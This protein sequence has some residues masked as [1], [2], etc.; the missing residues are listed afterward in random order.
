VSA[1]APDRAA[2][3]AARRAAQTVFGAPLVITAGAGTGK[4]TVLVARVLAWCLGPGWE[5]AERAC[6]KPDGASP[7]PREVAEHA[8]ERVVAI[9]FTEAAAAEMEARTMLALAQVAAGEEV[10]G[11]D[12]A[13]DDGDAGTRRA[14]AHALLAAFDRLHVQTIHAF[15]RRLLANHPLE[16][17]IH[18]RFRVD[19]RG[20]ERAVA[21][22][23]VLEARLRAMADEGDPDLE[24]ALLHGV[25]A[26][27]VAEMLEALLA[28]AVP[29]DAFAADPLA[30]ERVEAFVAELIAAV[31]ALVRAIGERFEGIRGKALGKTVAEAARLSSARLTQ[32]DRLPELLA[33]LETLWPKNLLDRLHEWNKGDWKRA[34][35]D[36]VGEAALPIGEAARVLRPLLRRALTVDVPLLALVHRTLAPLLAAASQRLREVGAESF[37]AL[38]RK[39]R[40]LLVQRPDVAERVRRDIDQ[41][42]VDEFQDTDA[43]QCEIVASLALGGDAAARPG[44]F[45][46]G[47]PKQSVYGWRNADIGAYMDFVARVGAE[48]GAVA[49]GLCVNHRSVPAV[50]DEVASVIEPAMRFEARVQ[51]PFEALLPSEKNAGVAGSGRA[52]LPAVEYWVSAD[53]DRD[54]NVLAAKTNAQRA[55]RREAA[56]LARDLRAVHEEQQI[57]WR[58]VAL[59]FRSTGDLDEYMSVLRSA[60]IPYTVDRDRSYYRR[61]EVVEA[62]A[63]VR[64]V[65]DPSDQIAQVAVL[66][67]AWVGVP[68]AAWRPLWDA[69]FPD[70]LRAALD[71]VAGARERLGAIATGVA[72]AIANLEVPGLASIA[73]WEASL[74]HALDVL[75]ALRR[76]WLADPVDAFIEKLRVLPLLEATE[77]ARHPGA[78]RLANLARFFREL[79]ASLASGD[80]AAVLRELRRDASGDPEFYEGRPQD[81]AED[82]VQVMTIHGAKGLDFEHVYV[83]QLHKGAATNTS[84]P[85][86]HAEIEGRLEWQLAVSGVGVASLGF[87]AVQARRKR[88]E[89]AELVRTLYVAMTRA[90]SRLVLAGCFDDA[91]RAESHANLVVNARGDA[92]RGARVVF[93]DAQPVGAAVEPPEVEANEIVSASRVEADALRLLEARDEAAARQRR[94]LGGCASAQ[95]P[96]SNREDRVARD[97]SAEAG[98]PNTSAPLSEAAEVAAAAGTAIHA[99]LERFDW[100]AEPD[101]EWERQCAWLRE[102]LASRVAASRYDAALERATS[103]VAKLA[104]GSLWP[105][106]REIAPQVLA[107]ELPALVRA[108][109]NGDGPVGY[110]AGA[111]D[112]VYRDPASGEIVV[113]DFK[114]DRIAQEREVAKRVSQH[115]AQAEL[116]RRAT[117]ETLR[118]PRAPRLELWF[119]DA[120]RVEVLGFEPAPGEARAETLGS[121][122]ARS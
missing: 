98:E 105:R 12:A 49:H 64:A 48:P 69:Q 36:A 68:D 20:A 62:A 74:L 103:L 47:D 122:K 57:R 1:A 10:V 25:G 29:A 82:A 104:A 24:E 46:V 66:R 17:G 87:E 50:L 33:D 59:L 100:D 110:I 88:V 95:V 41:L 2:D 65:L 80:A 15:C 18:P 91:T 84:A 51:P 109:A 121:E 89:S 96:E 112:L 67:S 93:L 83:L 34:E 31:D 11:Y 120:D 77:A 6:T 32:G 19:A 73:G 115:R 9:T 119:L 97:A 99:V 13:A 60:A 40:D 56:N 79:A 38:L 4:T 5:R 76:S 90:K 61:R 45:L 39:T 23:E 16:A 43:L 28:A 21:I 101:A 116:Y 35:G 3:C 42:L 37:D 26:P 85:L 113:A 27:E 102:S 55:L 107:R 75:V 92:L 81:P 30:P 53:W 114:T 52:N 94:A 72:L 58:D 86:M 71:D 118:L 8:L 44:L 78:F 63:L 70:A 7:A 108:E 106:L 111:I 117:L 14:R 54:A 22:R